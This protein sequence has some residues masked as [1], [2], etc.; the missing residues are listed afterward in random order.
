MAETAGGLVTE[1]VGEVS[2]VSFQDAQLGDQR[3]IEKLGKELMALASGRLSPLLVLDFA[4]VEYLSS[5]MLS[6]LVVAQK[7]VKASEGRMCL[8]ALHPVIKDALRLT[9]MDKLFEIHPDTAAAVAAL[10]PETE[11]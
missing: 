11:A 10:T 1:N 2:V 5:M 6:K 7:I 3:L 9:K 8:C 4:K